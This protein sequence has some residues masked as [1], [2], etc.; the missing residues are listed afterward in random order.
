MGSNFWSHS[1]CNVEN[2][3][4]TAISKTLMRKGILVTE[5]CVICETVPLL[6]LNETE[7]EDNGEVRSRSFQTLKS[8]RTFIADGRLS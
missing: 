8:T 1:P 7:D 6:F 3:R 4:V 2:V 5:I